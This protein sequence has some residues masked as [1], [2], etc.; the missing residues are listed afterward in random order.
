MVVY[1]TERMEWRPLLKPKRQVQIEL[2]ASTTGWGGMCGHLEV[3]G[4][5]SKDV[6][7]QPSNFRELLAILRLIQSF[8]NVLHNSCVQVLSDNLT[9]VAYINHLG[10][11]S[12][13][14]SRLMTMLFVTAHELGI[15]LTAK[16]LAGDVNGH[17]DRLL[18]ILSPYEWKLHPGVFQEDLWGPH[19]VDRFESERTR[20]LKRYNSLYL[21]P[22]TE[23][24]D[25]MMQD[26]SEENNFINPPF[27]MLPHVVQK[28]K[29]QKA[30]ATVIAPYWPAQ[31]W[32]HEI[33][34]L[35][36]APAFRLPN[37]PQVIIKRSGMP[38]PLKNQKW[39]IFAWRVCGKSD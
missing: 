28:I 2:D 11:T 30:T 15:T 8:R 22:E 33:K 12:R 14:M 36:I 1:F 5:W 23:A 6:S 35:V 18:R 34:K 38:E 17:A 3:S 39:K 4:S 10:G 19:S 24:V 37:I 16:Y 32:L 20:Q 9:S 25:A 27:W 29:E 7:F 31:T 21:D 26:W 13:L